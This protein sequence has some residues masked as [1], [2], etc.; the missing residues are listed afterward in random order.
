[1][2]A[3]TEKRLA[4]ITARQAIRTCHLCLFRLGSCDCRMQQS[5]AAAQEYISEMGINSI[6]RPMTGLPWPG[7]L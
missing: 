6:G 1:M 3:A 2:P 7:S 4:E 5:A